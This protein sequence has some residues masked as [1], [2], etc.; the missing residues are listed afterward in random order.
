MVGA[1][2]LLEVKATASHRILYEHE[3]PREQT[4]SGSAVLARGYALLRDQIRVL[5]SHVSARHREA[6]SY[7][8][9][10]RARAKAKK[11]V[12]SLLDE[13]SIQRGMAWRDIARLAGVSVS[14]VTKWRKGGPATGE[15]RLSLAK[16]AAFIDL[17]E[18]FMVQDPVGWLEL[19]VV[20]GYTVRHIDLYEG[21]RPILLLDIA[22]MRLSEEEALEQFD[23]AW[24]ERYRSEF[25]VFEAGD[26]NMSIR[27]K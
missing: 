24:R 18:A 5:D 7:H 3:R 20:D 8:L 1:A 2:G 4:A 11:S 15:N 9:D 26:G 14:A 10:E 22:D 21:G 23:P 6:E 12:P 17:L 25:E 27:K 19:P 13:L 16:L